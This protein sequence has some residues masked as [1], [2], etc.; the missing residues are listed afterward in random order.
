LNIKEDILKNVGNQTVDDVH[1][2]EPIFFKVYFMFSRNKE[3]HK[4]LEKLEGE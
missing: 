2:M 3:I 1:S 4:V